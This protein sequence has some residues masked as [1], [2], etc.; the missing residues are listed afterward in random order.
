MKPHYYQIVQDIPLLKYIEILQQI[1]L[2][3][4]Y[5]KIYEILHFQYLLIQMGH[6]QGVLERHHPI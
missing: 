4:F 2:K 3:H 5:L 1:F 6:S